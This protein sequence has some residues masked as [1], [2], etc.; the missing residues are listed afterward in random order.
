MPPLA[1]NIDL[2]RSFIEVPDV[3]QPIVCEAGANPFVVDQQLDETLNN[4]YIN[5]TAAFACEQE[6]DLQM[7]L[8]GMVDEYA[9][10]EHQRQFY[11]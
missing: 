5:T 8:A 4:S 2:L 11:N 10:E 7:S 1:E 3:V 6:P 9:S